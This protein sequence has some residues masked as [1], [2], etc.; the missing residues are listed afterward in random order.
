MSMTHQIQRIESTP[1]VAKNSPVLEN[2]IIHVG[3]V[4]KFIIWANFNVF[5]YG[6]QAFYF[7]FLFYITS[8]VPWRPSEGGLNLRDFSNADFGDLGDD[9][10]P[11]SLKKLEF[12]C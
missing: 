9:H 12:P 2:H 4:E 11:N 1:P 3:S 7:F 6:S 10:N 8:K 5:K